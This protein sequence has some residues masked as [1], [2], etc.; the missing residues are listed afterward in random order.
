M[1]TARETF[2]SLLKP[3]PVPQCHFP[4]SLTEGGC[5]KVLYCVQV[6]VVA[7][8]FILLAVCACLHQ[9]A[10]QPW[11]Q[12]LLIQPFPATDC[13][14]LPCHYY[15]GRAVLRQASTSKEK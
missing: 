4:P 6:E 7:R 15:T 12:P 9:E 11:F 2:G 14:V 1:N 3:H 13:T 10:E 8:K 5:L